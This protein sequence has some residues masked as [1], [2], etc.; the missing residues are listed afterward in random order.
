MLV[1]VKRPATQSREVVQR[2]LILPRKG[3]GI[4]DQLSWG[5]VASFHGGVGMI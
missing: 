1:N 3:T 2:E 4:C 5:K